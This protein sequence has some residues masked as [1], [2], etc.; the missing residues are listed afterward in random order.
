MTA[1]RTAFVT[2]DYPMCPNTI[3]ADHY[4][5]RET[6]GWQYGHIADPT[7]PKWRTEDRCPTH[8]IERMSA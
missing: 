4:P 1:R 7:A 3:E 2:C 5:F 6:G 8:P